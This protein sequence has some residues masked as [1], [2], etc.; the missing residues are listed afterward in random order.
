ML[1]IKHVSKRYHEA[2]PVVEDVSFTVEPGKIHGI[3]GPNGSGKT[4]L[5]KCLT[6]IYP[7]DSGEILVDGEPIFDNPKA[8]CKIGYVADN[9][10]FFPEYTVKKMVKFFAGIYEKFDQEDFERLNQTFQIP[11]NSKVSHLSKGQKMRLS[12][13]LNISAHPT[14]LIMDEPTSGLDAIAK[15]ELLDELVARV[16]YGD[17][18][19]IISSHNLHDIEKLCDTL[20]MFNRDSVSN[21]DL[22]ELKEAIQKYQ[23]VFPN[24]VEPNTLSDERILHFSNLGSVYTVIWKGTPESGDANEYFTEKGASFV[25]ELELSLEELFIFENK[26]E[27]TK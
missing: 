14:Y 25:E 17:M 5:I 6:G 21:G 19:V 22:D 7:S 20:T 12:F 18:A 10:N 13:M 4:T 2:I 3:I 16:D 26:K 27:A 24:G 8:K 23:V 11:L 15:A 1:E 9:G